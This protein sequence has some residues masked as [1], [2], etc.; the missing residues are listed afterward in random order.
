[1]ISAPGLATLNFRCSSDA[2][3][4]AEQRR[5][6]IMQIGQPELELFAKM[7][8]QNAEYATLGEICFTAPSLTFFFR[9]TKE[10]SWLGLGGLRT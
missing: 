5:K 2:S 9:S 10:R 7:W 4:R 6:G 3:R 8:P 1:M